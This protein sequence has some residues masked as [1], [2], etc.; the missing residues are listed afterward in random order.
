MLNSTTS[1]QLNTGGIMPNLATIRLLL[2][3]MRQF[4]REDQYAGREYECAARLAW[5]LLFPGLQEQLA[6]L[7]KSGPVWDGDT[8]MGHLKDQLIELGLGVPVVDKGREGF[9]A[10]TMLG[11]KLYK[12]GSGWR[13]GQ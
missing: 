7:V 9:T 6:S 10:A 8:L 13:N 2:D 1:G 3:L 4:E 11:L 5:Y 12:N